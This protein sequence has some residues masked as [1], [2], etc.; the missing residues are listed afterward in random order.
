MSSFVLSI[1]IYLFAVL[2]LSA[3]SN[4]KSQSF[5]EYI[6]EK[7]RR[8]SKNVIRA[9][10]DID[11]SLSRWVGNEETEFSCEQDREIRTIEEF[12]VNDRYFDA[13]EKSFLRVRLGTSIQSKDSTDYNY[14]IRAQIPLSRTKKDFQLFVDDVRDNYIE[15]TPS[16]N[17]ENQHMEVGVNF[18]AP[19]YS[20]IRSKYSI[21]ISGLSVA[22]RARYSKDFEFGKWLIQPVQQFKYSTKSEFSEETSLYIDRVFDELS[23][24]RT[25]LYR[26]TQSGINGFD[27]SATF[28]YYFTK[29]NKKGLS[30]SQQFWGNSRYVCDLKPK[31]YSGISDYASSISWRQNI[32]KTWIAYEIQPTIS[33][34]RKYDYEAN[35]ILN[36]YI[37]FYFGHI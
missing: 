4:I 9:F 13:T 7:Q 33:F 30:L 5:E 29:S 14:K 18:F 19:I 8:V 15:G 28:S 31:E 2:N 20:D 27:Y 22:A 34:H 36:F 37:D 35:Y 16:A 21:G 3:D 17:L 25:H 12:F 23:L 6:D 10:D 32:F 24:F 11:K 1:F 26:K